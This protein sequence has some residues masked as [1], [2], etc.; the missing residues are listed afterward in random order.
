M[1]GIINQFF[2][3]FRYQYFPKPKHKS[4]YLY[5]QTFA[6]LPNTS[7]NLLDRTYERALGMVLNKNKVE[8]LE[9]QEIKKA[10]A[11]VFTLQRNKQ[12]PCSKVPF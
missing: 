4:F 8:K 6:S 11:P 1:T 12:K 3:C 9:K 2:R 5:P 10:L 7:S